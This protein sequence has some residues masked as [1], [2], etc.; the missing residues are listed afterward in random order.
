MGTSREYLDGFGVCLAKA[1]NLAELHV[2]HY[3][4]AVRDLKTQLGRTTDV[5]VM[6]LILKQMRTEVGKR[7]VAKR[8]L[9]D[10]M[11]IALTFDAQG[12]PDG[13]PVDIA[14]MVKKFG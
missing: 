14:A 8:M 4:Q 11:R 9:D 5:E 7:A 3:D 6:T 13:L 1:V 12:D 10:M 2:E